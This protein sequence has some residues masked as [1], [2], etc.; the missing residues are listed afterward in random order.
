[1]K[2]RALAFAGAVALAIAWA[3]AALH[4]QLTTADLVLT[5]GKI[6]TVAGKPTI[7]QTVAVK[8]EPRSRLMRYAQPT[9]HV[10]RRVVHNGGTSRRL[11][12]MQSR[13]PR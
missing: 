2:G 5:N 1:M 12:R 7:A 10:R 13:H 8:W 6:I 11:P 3:G 4:A 9:N